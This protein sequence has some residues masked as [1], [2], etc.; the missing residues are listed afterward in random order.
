MIHISWK[1]ELAT[2]LNI[3]DERVLIRCIRSDRGKY[4]YL[5]RSDR[6]YGS[7]KQSLGLYTGMRDVRGTKIFASISNDSGGDFVK[8]VTEGIESRREV[9]LAD[10]INNKYVFKAGF[11]THPKV[12]LEKLSNLGP[13]EVCGQA[14]DKDFRPSNINRDKEGYETRHIDGDTGGRFFHNFHVRDVFLYY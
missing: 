12:T 1:I 11:L 5:G 3:E 2:P 4:I 14:A 13:L 6:L 9:Y 8:L 7:L 10:K